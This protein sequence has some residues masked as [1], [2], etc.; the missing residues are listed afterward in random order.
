MLDILRRNNTPRKYESFRFD[1]NTVSVDDLM[2][3][4]FTQKQAQSNEVHG[5]GFRQLELGKNE[6]KSE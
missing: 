2:R 3:L 1:P 5:E 6:N 4:G